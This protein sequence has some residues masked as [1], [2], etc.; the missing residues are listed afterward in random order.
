MN[1]STV[2]ETTTDNF[3]TTTLHIPSTGHYQEEHSPSLSGSDTS[4]APIPVVASTVGYSHQ[5]SATMSVPDGVTPHPMAPTEVTVPS[6]GPSI[7]PRGPEI[8]SPLQHQFSEPVAILII[9]GI[10]AAV[11]GIILLISCLI[12]RVTKKS[13]VD[14]QPPEGD[15]NGVPLSSIEQTA[16]QEFSNV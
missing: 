13:S 1:G 3:R 9:L 4:H 15:D 12:S 11:I 8:A 7:S 5:H 14:I 2:A 16:N 10:M 6:R